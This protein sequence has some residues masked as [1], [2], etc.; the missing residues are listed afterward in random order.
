M[1]DGYDYMTR[2]KRAVDGFASRPGRCRHCAL[3]RRLAAGAAL[4]AA[5]L[6]AIDMLVTRYGLIG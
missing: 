2:G 6:W 5:L 1:S 4:V 3:W